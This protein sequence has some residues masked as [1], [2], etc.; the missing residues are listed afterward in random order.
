MD[1]STLIVAVIII[2][3]IVVPVVLIARTGK[4]KPE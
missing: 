4:K 2:A 1:T 3:L